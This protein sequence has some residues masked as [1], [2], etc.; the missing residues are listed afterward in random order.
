MQVVPAPLP[1]HGEG[2]VPRLSGAR[3]PSACSLPPCRAHAETPLAG[4]VTHVR[5][6]DTIMVEGVAVRLQGL[7]A[8][9]VSEPDGGEAARFMRELVEGRVVV[10]RLT[11]DRTYDRRVGRYFLKGDDIAARLIRAGLGRDCARYSGGRYA[12][13]ET[14]QGGRLALPSYCVPR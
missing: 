1:R 6:G 7:H 4:R 8:P 12:T 9:E 14:G 2:C 11:G 13:D 3:L 5:D 10:C